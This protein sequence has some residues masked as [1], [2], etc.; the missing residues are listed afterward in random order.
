MISPALPKYTPK[1]ESFN[2]TF[3]D[4][5]GNLSLGN[6]E[7]RNEED[8]SMQLNLPLTQNYREKNFNV[9]LG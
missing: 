5:T 8:S 1:T 2:K 7:G 3:Q 9:L 6:R 4:I